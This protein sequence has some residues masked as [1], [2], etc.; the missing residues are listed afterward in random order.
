M[1]E[2]GGDFYTAGLVLVEAGG[3]RM[4]CVGRYV[5]LLGIYEVFTRWLSLRIP[6]KKF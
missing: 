2:S 4:E 1:V 5:L 3:W 6:K